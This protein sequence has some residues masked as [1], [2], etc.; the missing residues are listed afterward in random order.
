DLA[1]GLALLRAA[2]G[3]LTTIS[4]KPQPTAE[5]LDGRKISEPLLLGAPQLMDSLR[6]S[7]ERIPT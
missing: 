7:V 4:G 3:V 6:A 2:G 5:L 1:G